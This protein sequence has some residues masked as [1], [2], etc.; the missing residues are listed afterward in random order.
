MAKSIF[1]ISNQMKTSFGPGQVYRSYPNP[2]LNHAKHCTEH[3]FSS[4]ISE[5]PTNVKLIFTYMLH[6][7]QMIQL[8]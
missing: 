6:P 1:P 7:R 5:E 8:H 4:L 2:R 3:D